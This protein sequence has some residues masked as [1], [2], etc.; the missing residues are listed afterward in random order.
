M[1]HEPDFKAWWRKQCICQSGCRG[2]VSHRTSFPWRVGLGGKLFALPQVGID[3]CAA[4]PE[5]SAAAAGCKGQD[6]GFGVHNGSRS[7]PATLALRQVSIGQQLLLFGR[8][9]LVHLRHSW[10]SR[11]LVLASKCPLLLNQFA[12]RQQQSEPPRKLLLASCKCAF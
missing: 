9:N 10:V 12:V 2:Y 5:F 7:C 3:A 1:R 8:T 11:G 4:K 6:I